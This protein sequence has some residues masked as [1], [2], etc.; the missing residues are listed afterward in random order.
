MKDEDQFRWLAH[1]ATAD[2]NLSEAKEQEFARLLKA[3]DNFK[4]EQA[5][6]RWKDHPYFNWV[7]ICIDTVISMLQMVKDGDG[8]SD[9]FF[10][11]M[12]T[13]EAKA[14]ATE[15]LPQLTKIQASL[16]QFAEWVW[17]NHY[18]EWSKEA[19]QERIAIDRRRRKTSERKKRK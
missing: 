11:E 18:D 2:L 3:L 9:H 4:R 8:F 10:S 12:K 17:M 16:E 19:E 6:M 1:E 14:I 15:L 5:L 13:I 7:G